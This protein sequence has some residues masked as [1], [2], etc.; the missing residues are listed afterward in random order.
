MRK[1]LPLLFAALLFA[2]AERQTAPA[3]VDSQTPSGPHASLALIDTGETATVEVTIT[4]L[5]P[6]QRVRAVELIGPGGRR[7]AAPEVTTESGEAAGG[8]I[9]GRPSVGVGV[10]G[11]SSG[12]L[13]AGI[14]LGWTFGGGGYRP[15]EGERI[16]RASV[17]V[18]N[19]PFYAETVAS[20]RLAIR[21]LDSDGETR[22]A[23]IPAPAD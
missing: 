2:C 4:R 16:A 7:S 13:G 17:P 23:Y 18:P 12:R 19:Y 8:G 1:L 6:G 9:G 5:A 10:G 22:T 20:W 14:G 15:R 3:E 21:F 11:G